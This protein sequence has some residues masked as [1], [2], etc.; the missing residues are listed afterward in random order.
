VALVGFRQTSVQ[1]DRPPR[2]AGKGNYNRF[3]GSLRIGLNGLICFSGSLLSLS[4]KL[5]FLI[6][7][8]SFV[9][10]VLY[11]VMKLTGFPFPL[12][13]PTVVIL[14]L[15]MGGIQLISVGILGE[16]ISRIYEEVKNRPKFI[17][18]RSVG[19]DDK[20]ETPGT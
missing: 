18:D 1:F 13:N 3:L 8:L 5:G 20:R 10:A 11:L 2:Y 9:L 6:A 17:V 12:G 7:G 19:F 4:S 15:F 14:I 16:Y